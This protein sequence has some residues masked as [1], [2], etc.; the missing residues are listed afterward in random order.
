[1]PSTCHSLTSIRDLL[2]DTPSGG[3]VR[4]GEVARVRVSANPNVI[5][6]DDVSRR[7]DV[8]ASVRGRSL[9]A[10]TSDVQAHLATVKFPLE[11]HAELVGGATRRQDLLGR[12][13]GLGIGAAVLVFLL[14]Q[15]AFGSWRLATLLFLTLP[16]AL[17]GGVLAAAVVSGIS[18]F[19]LLVGL[20]TVLAIA[21]RNGAVLIRRCQ[22]LE[23]DEAEPFGP[24]LVVRASRERLVPILLTALATALAL[25]PFLVFGGSP[26]RE[27]V[28]PLAV[29]VVG[30]L[31][32]S[33]LL[34]LFVLPLAY[35]RFAS[36]GRSGVAAS[37]ASA[38]HAGG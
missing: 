2:I 4:L 38:G 23:R 19:A 5:E 15:A 16:L 30:G 26:G 34:S 10:V 33:T 3:H 31:V 28:H 22:Q 17:V 27:M 24:G 32:T 18:S 13:L 11:Y 25:L 8:A 36:G 21:T 7:V 14:L 35:L 12:T 29:V 9:D 6:H 1:M 37:Q 20:F